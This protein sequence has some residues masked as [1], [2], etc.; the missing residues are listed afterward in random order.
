MLEAQ[1][2]HLKQ[3]FPFLHQTL[4]Y[5]IVFDW[6]TI[7]M[8]CHGGGVYKSVGGVGI[9]G[10]SAAFGTRDSIH[11]LNPLEFNYWKNLIK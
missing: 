1:L 7:S 2:K 10:D 8:P 4:K 9:W 11:L 5:Y 6:I 3:V